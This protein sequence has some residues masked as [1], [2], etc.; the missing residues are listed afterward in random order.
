[1]FLMMISR[2]NYGQLGLGHTEDI[3]DSYSE[4]GNALQDTDL[5]TG[6]VVSQLVAGYRHVCAL[7][8]DFELKC[9]G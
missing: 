3:G 9:W 6:F 8:T 5:G 2:N 1:M 7:S 4:M